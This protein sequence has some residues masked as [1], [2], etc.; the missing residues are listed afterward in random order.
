ML[1]EKLLNAITEEVQRLLLKKNADYGDSYFEL[2][3][4]N[5]KK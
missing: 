5:N 2:R 4:E 1:N 3:N